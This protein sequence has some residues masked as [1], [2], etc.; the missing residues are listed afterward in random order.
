MFS[1]LEAESYNFMDAKQGYH[2]VLLPKG[3]CCLITYFVHATPRKTPFTPHLAL[4]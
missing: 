4:A 1:Q 3:M 2:L